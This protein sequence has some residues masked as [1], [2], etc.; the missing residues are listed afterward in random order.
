MKCLHLSAT[1][2]VRFQVCTNPA[3]VC[4]EKD[5]KVQEESSEDAI[6]LRK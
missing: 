6:T 2:S 3:C 5:H 4:K 1:V